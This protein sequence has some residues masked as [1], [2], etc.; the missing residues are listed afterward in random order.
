MSKYL[1]VALLGAVLLVLA[2]CGG[3]PSTPELVRKATMIDLYEVDAGEIASEKGQSDGGEAIRPTHGRGSQQDERG[4]EA[5]R[6]RREAGRG[7]CPAKPQQA[8]S[9]A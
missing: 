9:G 3:A 2:S 4:V 6:D 5:H 7:D 8:A 1:G